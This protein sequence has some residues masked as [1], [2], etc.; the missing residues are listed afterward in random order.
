M[1]PAR[2]CANWGAASE[3]QRT[4]FLIEGHL[5]KLPV[6]PPPD[7]TALHLTTEDMEIT[8]NAIRIFRVLR[9]YLQAL[10]NC[11]SGLDTLTH[12]RQQAAADFQP[13]IDAFQ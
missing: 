11:H 3:H 8:E 6:A 10:S 7:R 9:G 1:L 4:A 5:Y 13:L 12:I 2:S